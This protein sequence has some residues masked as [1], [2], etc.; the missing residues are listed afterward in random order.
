MTLTFDPTEEWSRWESDDR[1]SVQNF[2]QQRPNNL[3]TILHLKPKDGKDSHTAQRW[4]SGKARR[5]ERRHITTPHPDEELAK[6][7]PHWGIPQKLTRRR[8]AGHQSQSYSPHWLPNRVT[9]VRKKGRSMQA[10]NS[11]LTPRRIRPRTDDTLNFS[12]RC[13]PLQLTGVQPLAGCHSRDCQEMHCLWLPGSTMGHYFSPKPVW[14]SI[15]REKTNFA[16]IFPF[17][18]FVRHHCVII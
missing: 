4:P 12:W 18:L 8:N 9:L 17:M 2:H 13:L 15:S 11:T 16:V 3:W 14:K 1:N 6:E 7:E 10:S 5:K